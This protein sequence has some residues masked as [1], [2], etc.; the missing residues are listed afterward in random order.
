[1]EGFLGPANG[2]W[3]SY[4]SFFIGCEFS[5]FDYFLGGFFAFRS[6]LLRWQRNKR[7][8]N[9]TNGTAGQQ[10]GQRGRL[11]EPTAMQR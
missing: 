1:M 8:G 9:A 11:L 10:T 6:C 3:L 7:D 4:V 2:F 5:C